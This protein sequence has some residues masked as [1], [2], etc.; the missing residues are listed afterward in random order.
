[1]QNRFMGLKFVVYVA[2]IALMF[3]GSAT[4]FEYLAGWPFKLGGALFVLVQV[5][6]ARAEAAAAA[7]V[8]R[9]GQ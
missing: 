7:P 8:L 9:R 6:A 2:L 3:A 5:N 1:M 4:P